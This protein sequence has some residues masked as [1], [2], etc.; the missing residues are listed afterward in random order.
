MPAIVRKPASLPPVDIDT[1]LHIGV[2]DCFC[3]FGVVQNGGPVQPTYLPQPKPA[4]RARE[5]STTAAAAAATAE[6][7]TSL[8]EPLIQNTMVGRDPVRYRIASSVSCSST[9]SVLR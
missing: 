9:L 3:D 7:A 8:D 2:F 4:R 1:K 5:S 6:L